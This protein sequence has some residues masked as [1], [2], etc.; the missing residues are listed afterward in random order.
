MTHAY[1]NT[2][3][4]SQNSIILNNGAVVGSLN[5]NITS[6]S[7]LS[8]ESLA[9]SVWGAL[10]SQ[11]NQ[12]GTMGE[13]MNMAGTIINPWDE[14]INGSYNARDVMELLLEIALQEGGVSSLTLQQIEESLILAKEN[15]VL[16]LY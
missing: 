8:P 12:V 6:L 16:G 3:I 14:I 11:Y 2:N 5:A 13:K 4:F 15:T 7:E 1:M 10:S 9:A